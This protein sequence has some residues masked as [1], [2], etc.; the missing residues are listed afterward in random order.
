[1]PEPPPPASAE[2]PYPGLASF[3]AE[4][5]R[6]FYGRERALAALL[7]RLRS[8]MTG[9]GPLFVVAASGAG[10]SSLLRA[11]LLPALAADELPGS[12]SWPRLL[13]TPTDSPTRELA[14]RLAE[15]TGLRTLGTA[16]LDAV[17]NDPRQ[18]V[19]ALRDMLAMRAQPGS[20]G[21]DRVVLVIDQFEELFTLCPDENVRRAFVRALFAAAT[22]QIDG[23][24][25]P[26]VV[27]V[28]IRADFYGYCAGFPELVEA[29][30]SGQ[31]L[32]GPM[33]ATEL[34]DA[35]IC[36]A[37]ATG[38]RVDPG[39]VELLLH[40]LGVGDDGRPADPGSLPLLAHALLATWERREG[41]TMTVAGYLSIGGLHG[42]IARTA[43]D[44]YGSFDAASQDAARELLLRMVR[45]GEGADD[46]RRRV[47]RATLLAEVPDPAAGAFALD[48]LIAA[49]LVT[50]DA[51]DVQLAHEALLRSWPRLREWIDIDRVGALT[52]QQI[53][54][55]TQEW[56]SH[57]READY[58]YAGRRLASALEQV[59]R[60]GERA[61]LSPSA[62]AFMDASV[63]AEAA[64]TRRERRRS[65]ILVQMV[66][67]LAVLLLL[68]TGAFV[69]ALNTRSHAA[70]A[71]DVA[72]SQ[73]M[74][75]QSDT[76]SQ[77]STSQ[78]S[79]LAAAAYRLSPTQEAR[80]SVLQSFAR[81]AAFPTVYP[82]V[83]TDAIGT[84]AYSPDGKLIA[85]GSDDGTACLWVAGQPA[86]GC[87]GRLRG[88]GKAVKSVAF[89]RDSRLLATGD[90]NHFVKIFDISDPAHP[91]QVAERKGTGSI[92]GLSFD[93]KADILAAGGFGP[94]GSESILFDVGVPSNPVTLSTMDASAKIPG[95]RRVAQYSPD[96]QMVVTSDV[97][98]Y[99]ML[100]NVV[101]PRTPLLVDYLEDDD[102]NH[103]GSDVYAAAFTAD[104]RQVI[105]GDT[106]ASVRLFDVTP[107]VER[108]VRREDKLNSVAG[109]AV[110]PVNKT[111]VLSSDNGSAQLVDLINNETSTPLG[112]FIDGDIAWQS[113]FS[114][115]G[116]TLATAGNDGVLRTW[117]PPGSNL[118]SQNATFFETVAAQPKTHIVATGNYGQLSLWDTANGYRPVL[119][120]TLSNLN[121]VSAVRFSP[122]GRYLAGT[123]QDNSLNWHAAMW[124]VTDVTH[125]RQLTTFADTTAASNIQD[126]DVAFSPDGKLVAVGRAEDPATHQGLVQLY[127]VSDPATPRFV[128][129]YT[130]TSGAFAVA[131]SH[132]SRF[133]V[134]GA[135]DGVLRVLRID[136]GQRMSVVWTIPK[137][138][139]QAVYT[140]KFSADGHLLAIGNGD[141]D[142]VL[143]D[144]TDPAH[145]RQVSVAQGHTQQVNT[146]AFSPDGTELASGSADD[147]VRL[148]DISDPA[149]PKPL[150]NLAIGV[151][152]YDVTFS[153]DGRSLIPV[154][155]SDT[156]VVFDLNVDAVID[157]VC[158]RVGTPIS[159]AQWELDLPNT[160]YSPPCPA[161]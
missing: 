157:A 117:D 155:G 108:F 48:A 93:P 12:A 47:A 92:Y 15:A 112:Y 127:D 97:G 82:T 33:N 43:E 125:P 73:W 133:L 88:F 35:I 141:D 72:R 78:A 131:F 20:A 135:A 85:T 61:G 52:R 119:K 150:A 121:S 147:S 21:A 16:R 9:E 1:M 98:G 60:G 59:G 54:E 149:T 55:A 84:V 26:A 139:S 49:R 90:D 10:K 148:W 143:F 115:D 37:E 69:W 86:R 29:L 57:N 51:D 156:A 34:R 94:A 3:D 62:R 77:T 13:M 128:D 151:S 23:G 154:Y 118:V 101:N 19:A 107:T 153:P 152:V 122:D 138:Y 63:A 83:H 159:K 100:W 96:G 103:L 81:S 58:L 22:A 120:A 4:S 18:F 142:V 42:A 68:A 25:P 7:R 70:H 136:D 64:R 76:V 116:R 113:A 5:S 80:S 30:Q 36:P 53:T 87:V 126:K 137:A 134:V 17:V 140:A 79:Q 75:K 6:F 8:R 41:T 32:L 124:D 45:I 91:R 11:G 46:T 44:T 24:V 66:A 106:N 102:K 114:P 146:I 132:D 144:M 160:T 111:V 89:S 145:P 31:V 109:L 50:V 129:D 71:R 130:L 161:R 27:V 2:C 99:V 104:S 39:L 14:R 74:A 56:E 40:D 65:A 28:G 38:L 123:V 158:Q 110:S 67:V 95:L 105:T